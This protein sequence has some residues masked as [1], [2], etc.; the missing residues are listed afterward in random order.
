LSALT[1]SIQKVRDSLSKLGKRG[2]SS[3]GGSEGSGGA[4]GKFDPKAVLAWVKTHPAIVACVGVM[5]IVP[6]AA[7]WVASDIHAANDEAAGKRAQEMAALEKLEKSTVEISLPGVAKEQKVGVVNKKAVDAYKALAQKLHGDAVAIQRAALEH[8]QRGRKALFADIRRTASNTNTI[9][10]TVFDAVYAHAAAVLKDVRAGMPPSDESLTEQLQ[11][12]QDQFIATL[13]KADRKSLSEDERQQLKNELR[14]KRLQLYADAAVNLSFYADIDTIGLPGSP[15]EAG[16]PPSETSLFLWQWR[17]WIIEDI[18]RAAASANKPYRSV[19]DAPV[20][21]VLSIAVREDVLPKVAAPAADAPADGSAAPAGDGAAAPPVSIPP[22][23][24]KAPVAY[25]FAKSMTGRVSNNL[26]DVRTATVRMVV[27]SSML[28]EVLNAIARQ[29]FM[30]VTGLEV[31]SA[32]AFAAADSGFVYGGKPVCEIKLTLESI[33]M[34]PWLAK[35]MP[36]ELRERKG[37]DGSTTDDP[38]PEV[39]AAAPT[40]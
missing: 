33:W 8:N 12:R 24:M 25:D 30:T 13:R 18:L 23:D 40:T 9:A 17:E 14:D 20:K 35:L 37:T 27:A 34:R 36:K 16:S 5:V 29:N 15:M 6:V 19:S 11:R 38:P 10:E 2:G 4:G 26:Y 7:W 28:P 1:D 32:D 22:I 3:D 21:R 39:P 31:A